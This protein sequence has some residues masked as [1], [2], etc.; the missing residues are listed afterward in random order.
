MRASARLADDEFRESGWRGGISDQPN[1]EVR[2]E[3]GDS[4]GACDCVVAS[5]DGGD[6][7][8]NELVWLGTEETV[9]TKFWT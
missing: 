7:D 5:V 8:G 4:D 3:A 6:G 9:C 2:R 1:M